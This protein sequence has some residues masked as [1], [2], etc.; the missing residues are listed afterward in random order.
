MYDDVSADEAGLESPAALLVAAGRAADHRVNLDRESALFT[1]LLGRR[2]PPRPLVDAVFAV[3]WVP[4]LEALVRNTTALAAIPDL[5]DRLTV[6]GDPRIALA[7]FE[8]PSWTKRDRRRV[9]A[10]ADTRPE[11]RT[12]WATLRRRLVDGNDRAVLAAAVVCPFPDVLTHVLSSPDVRPTRAERLR[13]LV[14]LR[15]HGGEDAVRA[16]LGSAQA[17]PH[18]DVRELLEAAGT[19]IGDD[20]LRAA[21]IEAEGTVG[22]IEELRHADTYSDAADS[23]VW[24]TELDVPALLA[25]HALIPFDPPAAQALVEHPYCPADL[26]IALCRTHPRPEELLSVS[27]TTP[28]ATALGELPPKRVTAKVLKALVERCTDGDGLSGEDLF[29][30]ARPAKAVLA[31]A[32]SDSTCAPAPMWKEFHAR[33]AELVRTGL[34][35][36][37]A[38][39]HTVAEHLNRF[40]GTVPELVEKGARHA[41]TTDVPLAPW[42]AAANVPGHTETPRLDARRRAFVVLADAADDRTIDALAPHVDG[43]TAYDITV[44]GRWRPARLTDLIARGPSRELALTARHRRLPAEAV[45][46]L[47]ALDDPEVNAGLVYQVHANGR[48]LQDLVQG[49]PQRPHPAGTRLPLSPTLRAELLPSGTSPKRQWLVPFVGSGDPDLL[50]AA[51]AVVQIGSRHLQLKMALGQ[52]ERAGRDAVAIPYWFPDS[53]KKLIAALRADP[54]SR[55]ALETL[56]EHVRDAESAESLGKRLRTATARSLPQ[57]LNE[58]YRWDW[59]VVEAA[60]ARGHLG[61]DVVRGLAELPHC[62]DTLRRH[63]RGATP[64]RD[65][66]PASRATLRALARR[67]LRAHDAWVTDALAEGRF[68]IRDLLQHGRPAAVLPAARIFED[69]DAGALLGQLVRDHLDGNPEAWV[70][71]LR[72]LDTFAGTLPELLATAASATS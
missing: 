16:V 22:L 12:S 35:T 67:T 45:A 33:L 28:P 56:R 70:V 29:V 34:G 61:H 21:L 49:V 2:V 68:T 11:W 13:A 10:A 15:T 57:L 17:D 71:A 1:G 7:V 8:E 25:A 59:S 20:R 53:T 6:T 14:S 72:L 31:L 55:T 4:G 19:G 58:G 52:W 36:D 50:A 18:P 40:R 44:H 43:R 62:P 46:P 23:V 54:D 48:L 60:N 39:W 64:A 30:H 63:R 69:H 42:P 27:A 66:E 24:R 38:A 5:R 51:L 3:H 26:L 9:L 41:A 32:H 65:G 37:A 47:A